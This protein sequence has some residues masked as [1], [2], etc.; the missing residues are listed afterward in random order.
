MLALRTVAWID[1]HPNPTDEKEKEPDLTTE[2]SPDPRRFISFTLLLKQM[3]ISPLT[4]IT[5]DITPRSSPGADGALHNAAP[6][7]PHREAVAKCR[8]HLQRSRPPVPLRRA[9]SLAGTSHLISEAVKDAVL[10][11]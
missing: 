3:A 9:A 11:Q 2:G 4:F 5:T 1:S 10:K 8:S 6:E 7:P